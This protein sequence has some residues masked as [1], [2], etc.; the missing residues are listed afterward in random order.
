MGREGLQIYYF[1]I[2]YR[3]KRLVLFVICMLAFVMMNAQAKQDVVY[4]KNGGII[5]GT[6]TEQNS[7]SVKISTADGNLFVYDIVEVEK[8]QKENAVYAKKPV[9][10]SEPKIMWGMIGGINET[11][12]YGRTFYFDEY[13]RKFGVGG[14]IGVVLD[15]AVGRKR[16]WYFETG[17][18]LQYRNGETVAEGF[19]EWSD[20]LKN[21][22][23]TYNGLNV[24]LPL[25]FNYHI[26][27]TDKIR[28]I[29]TFGAALGIGVYGEYKD[30][31]GSQ[32]LFLYSEDGEFTP[33]WLDV[34]CGARIK[35][36]K[37]FVGGEIFFPISLAETWGYSV[38]IG[39]NF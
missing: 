1:E 3:M 10:T 8:I 25:K 34:S 12:E 7:S 9:N 37:M 14:Q 23:S 30:I 21:Y 16:N 28:I 32:D 26:K 33:A 6:I 5:R 18:F 29:P 39:C 20:I 19:D 22:S 35:Y 31:H 27:I 17:F 11:R 13:S 4:L 24:L 15:V 2:I 38:N 36:K